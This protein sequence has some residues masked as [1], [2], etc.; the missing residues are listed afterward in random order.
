MIDGRPSELP[1]KP[2]HT[3]VARGRQSHRPMRCGSHGDANIGACLARPDR[4]I[5]SSTGRDPGRDN[6]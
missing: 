6:V 4:T 5:K 1:A 2:A 3:A